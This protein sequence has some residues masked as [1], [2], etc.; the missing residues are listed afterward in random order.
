[1]GLRLGSGLFCDFE[2]NQR[3]G[4]G[5]GVTIGFGIRTTMLKFRTRKPDTHF[6]KLIPS[7]I[8]SVEEGEGKRM[9]RGPVSKDRSGE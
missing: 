5:I 3:S 4:N 8:S 1:M 9:R 7:L 2:W 6:A